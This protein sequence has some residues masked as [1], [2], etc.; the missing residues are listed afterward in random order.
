M[1]ST[2]TSKFVDV[3]EAVKLHLTL[4]TPASPTNSNAPTLFFLH[5]WGGSSNT[6]S[7]VINI[8][9][10]YFPTV[11]LS[12]RGWGIS[13]GPEES[14]AYTVYEFCSDVE[15][16]IQNLDL[17]SV[18]LVGHSMGGKVAVAVAGRHGL[19]AGHLKGLALLAPAPPGPL[20]LP[21]PSMREQ[22]LHAFDNTENAEFVIRTVLAASDN[23]TLTDELVK[24]IAEDMVRGN[25]WAKAAWPAYGMQEDIEEL[26]DRVDVP[27]LVVAGGSDIIEPPE[28]M[29]TVIRDKLDDRLNGKASLV[30]V[31]GSGHILPLEKPAEVAQ[32]VREFVKYL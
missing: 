13:T 28:R 3:S 2:A 27:V 21:N 9:S 23:S 1:S 30:V 25:K 20:S 15:A 11:A 8:L 24:S 5:F 32:A 4:T 31:E 26:F 14:G 29:K 19:P 7:S 10:P 22:Q 12:F 16:V 6:F 18:V 17:K